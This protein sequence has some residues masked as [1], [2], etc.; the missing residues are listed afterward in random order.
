MDR[1]RE[2]E[3]VGLRLPPAGGDSFLGPNGSQINEILVYIVIFIHIII[4]IFIS[5]SHQV[6]PARVARSKVGSDSVFFS[7][8]RGPCPLG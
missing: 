8:Y 3:G 5:R 6:G 1:G 2:E 4:V 7:C